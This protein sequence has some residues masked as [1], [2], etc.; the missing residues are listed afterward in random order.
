M[1][2]IE[3]PLPGVLEVEP[4]VFDDERGFFLETYRTSRYDGNGMVARFKQG[5]HTH[6]DRGTLRGLHYQKARPQ[7]KLVFAARGEVLD[8]AVDIRRGSPHFGRW[9]AVVLNDQN[10][11]QLFIPPDFAHGFCVL[12]E[13]VDLMYLLTEEYDP[14]DQFGIRWNDPDI[15]V[16]W[17]SD[18]PIL[19]EKDEICPFLS[20]L[21]VDDLPVFTPA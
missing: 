20:D 6:S 9:H 16:D 7:G 10:H 2:V 21:P 19:S 3:T 12:S 15:G 18:D 17:P 13:T 5:N 4:N 11:K 14:D 1:K 8:V